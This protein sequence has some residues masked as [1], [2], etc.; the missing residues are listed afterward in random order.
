MPPQIKPNW[1]HT[2]VG[3]ELELGSRRDPLPE[4]ISHWLTG[5][6]GTGL[7][8][9][10]ADDLL[11]L[12]S[13]LRHIVA[14]LLVHVDEAE[15]RIALVWDGNDD[16]PKYGGRRGAVDSGHP[17][18]RLRV[19]IDDHNRA[20]ETLQEAQ[21]LVARLRAFVVELDPPTGLLRA[22]AEGWR[23]SP[24]IP[25][26]VIVFDNEESFLAA[27]PRRAATREWGGQ[28][29]AGVEPFGAYWRRDGDDDDLGNDRGNV[30]TAG[31]WQLGFIV[32]TGEIYAIRRCNYLPREVWLLGRN[33]ETLPEVQDVVMPIMHRMREPNSLILAA[34]TVHAAEIWRIPGSTRLTPLPGRSGDE[35]K[36]SPGGEASR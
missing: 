14:K 27:D 4:P 19:A 11:R 26:S 3:L 28:T 21:A 29:I 13:R 15:R 23:R 12:E 36:G 17:S 16:E 35:V 8:A 33:F 7:S 1:R 6:N 31:P 22:A 32:R 24:A 2:D 30:L 20:V 25:A 9:D 18:W 10:A 5:P 34:G